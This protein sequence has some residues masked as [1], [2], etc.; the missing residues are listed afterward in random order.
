MGYD[1]SILHAEHIAR[2]LTPEQ[3][4]RA[5]VQTINDARERAAIRD[6]KE[7]QNQIANLL[8]LR[9]IWCDQDAMHKRRTGTVGTPDFLFPYRG[10]FVAWECKPPWDTK[11]REEQEE[12]RVCI[13]QQL[14]IWRLITSVDDA[15]GHLREMDAT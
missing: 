14:G 6:E 10:R 4:S 11:L 13:L 5:G 8:R 2:L 1:K 12:A 9:G 3:R 15:Q 7:L